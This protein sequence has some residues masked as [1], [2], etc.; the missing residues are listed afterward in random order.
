MSVR[1]MVLIPVE[2]YRTMTNESTE[3]K[4]ESLE[5]RVQHPIKLDESSE[6]ISYTPQLIPRPETPTPKQEI[7]TVVKPQLPQSQ[8]P[9]LQASTKPLVK[10]HPQLPLPRQHISTKQVLKT[11]TPP[12]EKNTD[13]SQNL[14][15][16]LRDL[17]I[18]ASRPKSKKSKQKKLPWLKM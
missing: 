9:I 1:K 13:I 7:L 12:Q 6:K 16:G 17:L 11:S 5:N 8:P 15:K 4:F 14:P 10:P 18:K 2:K 3:Q